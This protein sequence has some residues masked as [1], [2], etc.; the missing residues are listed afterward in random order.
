MIFDKATH[1]GDQLRGRKNTQEK[2][3]QRTNLPSTS[4]EIGKQKR[5]RHTTGL[6]LTN[7]VRKVFI[8]PDRPDQGPCGVMVVSKTAVAFRVSAF[9]PVFSSVVR[10]G[11]TKSSFVRT[12]CSDVQHS[13]CVSEHK[14]GSYIRNFV[15]GNP[16]KA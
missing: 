1:V 5:K 4:E 10:D 2:R 15:R 6:R 11:K 12:L 16:A 13:S 9:A 7:T 8:D 14:G 3:P